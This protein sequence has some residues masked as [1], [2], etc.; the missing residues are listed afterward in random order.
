MIDNKKFTH[1]GT[2]NFARYAYFFV[3]L[4]MGAWTLLSV[5]MAQAQS[6]DMGQLSKWKYLGGSQDIY[7]GQAC[8]FDPYEL[9]RN[10]R[11]QFEQDFKIVVYPRR[12]QDP[13]IVQRLRATHQLRV[14]FP[15]GCERQTHLCLYDFNVIGVNNDGSVPSK[16]ESYSVEML[17]PEASPYALQSVRIYFKGSATGGKRLYWD[18]D[19]LRQ[20]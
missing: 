20:E 10:D 16:A 5:D 12:P 19:A 6:M 13:F 4:F 7:K 17:S 15:A 3:T 2:A 9:V 11:G 1:L 8:E 14:K 18:C